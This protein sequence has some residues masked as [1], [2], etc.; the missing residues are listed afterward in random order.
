MR[1][2]LLIISILFSQSAL[3]STLKL[4]YSLF[5]GYMKTMY[6]LD[7]QDV[8][9]AFYLVEP[10]SG[11]NCA[12]DQAEIVVDERREQIDFQPQGRLLP[13]YSDEH[14]KDG[15]MIEVNTSSQGTQS[16]DLP[17]NLRKQ[18]GAD[19]ARKDSYS[20]LLL[21]NWMM[22]VFYDMTD[23]KIQN[24]QSTFTPMFID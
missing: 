15:A 17:P 18:K 22:H 19:K 5:F 13:F 12:I 23:D 8:T 24:Q 14:R 7:Y 2:T 6:K 10:E 3:S 1:I 21:G 16:F 11:D 9:T 4:N 20:A